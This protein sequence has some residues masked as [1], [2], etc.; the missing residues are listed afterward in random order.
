M[1]KNLVGENF[2][3]LGENDFTYQIGRWNENHFRQPERLG[4][5]AACLKMYFAKGTNL[6]KLLPENHLK[7]TS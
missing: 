3:L 5:I 1:Q 2:N 4:K 7:Y 6:S